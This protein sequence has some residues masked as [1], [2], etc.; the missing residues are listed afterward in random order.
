MGANAAHW[1]L[2]VLQW[3]FPLFP[4]PSVEA[5]NLLPSMEA[6]NLLPCKFQSVSLSWN[7]RGS[8]WKPVEGVLPRQSSWNE[9]HVSGST[10]KKLELNAALWKLP[11]KCYWE[12]P[13]KLSQ[14]ASDQASNPIENGS[15]PLLPW[16]LPSIPRSL[17]GTGKWITLRVEASTEAMQ[18][19][20]SF[21]KSETSS[22]GSSRSPK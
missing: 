22:N 19:P 7:V 12:L 8:A 2:P 10:W 21:N 18:A 4:L 15:S 11:W 3:K 16:K 9:V 1:R 17:H 6:C 20:G 14:E 5:S 13:R